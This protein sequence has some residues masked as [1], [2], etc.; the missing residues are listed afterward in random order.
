[1][2]PTPG[3]LDSVPGSLHP[4]HNGVPDVKQPA[5]QGRA[6]QPMP[7]P[8]NDRERGVLDYVIEYI[9]TNTYPPTV[10]EIGVALSIPSTRSVSELI[11]AL[12]RKGWIERTPARS[13]GLRVIG[14]RD[15]EGGA[16]PGSFEPATEADREWMELA[17]E[18]AR[19][20]GRTNEVPVGAVLAKDGSVLAESGNMTRTLSDPTAHAEMVVIRKAAV[21]QPG[22]R[23]LGTTLYVTLEPCSMCSGAIVLAKVDR[24]VY[25]APDPKTGMCGSLGMI[26]Q[27]ARLNHSVRVTRGVLEAQSAD[28]LK[29]FFQVRR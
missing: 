25:A 23:L 14:G 10:R 6:Q 16:G 21:R 12:D 7:E 27:N 4:G 13:R 8:L 28:L 22:G 11:G 24:L 20:A 9:R 29:R 18:Q 1:L 19:I 26:V 17:L 15:P 2:P 5:L 3:T